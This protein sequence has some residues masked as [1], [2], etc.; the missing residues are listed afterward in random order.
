MINILGDPLKT[1][2]LI[3]KTEVK[4]FNVSGSLRGENVS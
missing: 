2:M 4:P 1:D 3:T